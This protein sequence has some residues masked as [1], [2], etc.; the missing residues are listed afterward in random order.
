ML[1]GDAIAELQLRDPHES[2]LRHLTFTSQP[3]RGMR[4]LL[5]SVW[6][7]DPCIHPRPYFQLNLVQFLS[8]GAPNS[9]YHHN[10]RM[11]PTPC[12]DD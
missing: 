1:V 3:K 12:G 9:Y 10:N 6:T 8:P 7:P 5:V 2:L 11:S 4:Q